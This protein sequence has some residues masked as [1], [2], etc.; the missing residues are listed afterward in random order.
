MHN[1]Q[2]LTVERMQA[3]EQAL[4][5]SKA[6]LARAAAGFEFAQ[7]DLKRVRELFEAGT[8]SIQEMDRAE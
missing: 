3:A 2:I 6:V 4:Q 8:V 1:S 7:N 5:Q